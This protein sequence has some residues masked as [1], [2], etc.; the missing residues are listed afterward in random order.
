VLDAEKQEAMI[1][2]DFLSQIKKVCLDFEKL[3][4]KKKNMKSNFL[5]IVWLEKSQKEKNREEKCTENLS[6]YKEKFFFPNMR[7]K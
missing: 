7:G 4:G 1:Y 5:F 2:L 6:C 3:E